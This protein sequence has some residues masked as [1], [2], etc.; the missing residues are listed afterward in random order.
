[1]KHRDRDMVPAVLVKAMFG[2]MF[3][4]V[5]LVG[6]ASYT[7]RP[8]TAVPP[9]S[10]IV[11]ERAISLIGDRSNGVQVL[12]ADGTQLAHST[13]AK[14]GFI[15][16][17]WTAVSRERTVKGASLDAPLR[18]VRRENGHVAVIDDTTGWK[19]ELIGYG[20]DNVAAFAKLID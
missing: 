3:A 11:T 9:H 6:Y 7:D 15:D 16:V 13:D 14:S 2:L 1:M 18:L 12:A 5:A 8:V 17:I 20:Q 10:D 19:I 4:A